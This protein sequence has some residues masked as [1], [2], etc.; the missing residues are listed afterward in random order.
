M[1]IVVIQ[2]ATDLQALSTRLLTGKTGSQRAV[3]QLRNLNP[4]VEFERI[5]PGTVLV[6]PDAPGFRS[7][8]STSVAGE[9]FEDLRA[10]LLASLEAAGDRAR[11]GFDALQAQQKDVLGV[12]KSKILGRVIGTD[13][14]L[15]EQVEAAKQGFARDQQDAKTADRTLKLLIKQSAAEL[16]AIAKLLA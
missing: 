16:A 2:H 7:D 5:K 15:V 14:D 3:E 11:G 12:L 6:I 9:A 1:R 10:H 8:E 4:H 13:P